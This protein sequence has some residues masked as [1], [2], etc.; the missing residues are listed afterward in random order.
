MEE[1]Q[2]YAA[3]CPDY[4]QAEACIRALVEQMGG[5]G[6]FVRPE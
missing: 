5:M 2:V 3:S 4:E 1:T 6:R